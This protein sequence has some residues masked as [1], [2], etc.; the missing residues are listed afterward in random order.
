MKKSDYSELRVA[1]LGSTGSVGTQALDVIRELG[2]R[3]VFLSA[4][5]NASLL[6]R[7][8]NEFHPEAVCLTDEKKGSDFI[9]PE[10]G[11]T[12][13]FLGEEAHLKCIESISVDVIIHA[14]SGLSGISSAIKASEKGVRLAIANKESIITLGD[15]IQNNLKRTGGVLIPVDSEHSAIFQCLLSNKGERTEIKKLI[16]TASGGPFFGYTADMLKNVT[17]AMALAHPTW[18]MGPKITVDCSTM[19]NK[20]FEIIEAVRLFGVSESSVQ[21]VVHRQSIIH[22]MVEYIDSTVIAQLGSPDMRAPI[23][24]AL[25][26]PNRVES[27]VSALDF[28]SISKLTFDKPDEE[29]F[30]LLGIA[31]HAIR[32]GGVAPAVLIS[33]DEAAVSSFLDGVL[34][35]EKIPLVVEKTLDKVSY[36]KSVSVT[37]VFSAVDDADKIAKSIIRNI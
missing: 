5:S 14:V 6:S 23:L 31:R 22:S 7:Q 10:N 37:N 34:P 3:V 35:F 15:I 21:V 28:T 27:P 32:C 19:M 26:F 9:F 11:K 33:A 1:V 29:V 4:K 18:K 36:E 20:G 17:P 25:T 13:L 24:F 12:E 8:A 16:L 2:C 30:P